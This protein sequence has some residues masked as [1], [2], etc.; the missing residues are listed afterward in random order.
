MS[1]TDK[2]LPG[3][4]WP[5]GA[6]WDGQG[7]NFAV[8]SAHASAIELC[9]FDDAGTLQTRCEPLPG[10]TDD[11]RHGY[12]PKATPGLIYGL[13]AHGDWQPRHGHYFNPNKLLLDPYAREVV[14]TFEW[15]DENFPYV[16]PSPQDTPPGQPPAMD[17]R[18]NA[19][20]ALKAR[21][22][23]EDSFDWSGDQPPGVP[24]PDTVLY[25]AHVKGFS[26]RNPA[27]PEALRGSYAGLADPASLAHLKR[28]GITSISLLPVHYALDEERLAGMGLSNYWGYN[29]LAFFAP[30]VRLA[31]QQGGVNPRDEFRSMV[32]ALHAEGLEVILDVVYNHTPEAD[33]GGPSISFRGLDNASYYRLSPE[34][35]VGFENHSGC[36]NTLDIRQPRVLQLVM[37]SL[38]Y[39][40]QRMHVDGFRFDLAPVLGR[41][42]E[43]FE[44]NGAFFTAV[45]QDPVLS[46]VKMIAEP[47]DI[48]PGGYQ[49]GGFAKG[50]LEWNDHFRDGMRSFWLQP[51]EQA[52]SLG[53]F[54]RRLCASADLYQGSGRAPSTS[55]NYLVSHDGFTLLDLVS[56]NERH[57]EANGE[58][59]RDGHGNNLSN[60]CGAEGPTDDSQINEQR[61]RMQRALLATTLLAQGTPMLCAGDELGHSQQGNNNPYCQDNEITWIDWTQADDTLI[62]FTAWVL[63]LRRQLLPFGNHWYSGLSDTL[64]LHDLHWLNSS[65][66]VLQ[67]QDWRDNSKRVLGCLIGQPGRARAPLL[68]LVN[69][70]AE[71]RDFMLPAGVWQAVLDTADPR[72][73]TRWQGQGEAPLKLAAHSLMLLVVA[74]T[75]VQF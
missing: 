25:E 32:K 14:G 12:L 23:Q 41:S 20:G 67:D 57:N 15:C 4:P 26:K 29:T 31:S 68:L 8:F 33:G 28:L 65:G 75:E 40:V 30:S 36:G 56:H 9:L 10:H 37:D 35:P 19:A 3:K 49:V 48:G 22:V 52:T 51:G 63:S 73:V 61:G 74:G 11:I 43:G 6:S 38:R 69:P 44:R 58:D 24:L 72:G 45:A 18:D 59:N 2:L 21:V 54:A 42:S 39:W 47:W 64:G 46:R 27:V 34:P 55:V 5:L 1:T 17:S 50:W 70:E 71:D 60:N 66:E 62:D 7:V 16:H 13:R 53:D